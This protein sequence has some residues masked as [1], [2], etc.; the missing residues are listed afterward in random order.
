MTLLPFIKASAIFML[1]PPPSAT[2]TIKT[3]ILSQNNSGVSTG[4][5][6]GLDFLR[7][8][9]NLEPVKKGCKYN[10]AHRIHQVSKEIIYGYKANFITNPDIYYKIIRWE[11]KY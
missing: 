4:A 10:N 3:D 11:K 2:G 7:D 5:S 6:D 9:P 1:D 8:E